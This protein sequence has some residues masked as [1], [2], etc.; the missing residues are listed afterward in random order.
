MSAARTSAARPARHRQPS[1]RR[2][3]AAFRL[4]GERVI[5]KLAG[6]S[7]VAAQFID[8]F[9]SANHDHDYFWEERWI[10]DE[11]YAKLFPRAVKA[12]LGEAGIGIGD[13]ST[14]VL[15]SPLKNSAAGIAKRLGYEG[16]IA[17][18]LEA[19]VGYTGTAHPLLM[20]AGVL[21]RAKAGDRILVL[22]FGQ[23]A[24]ALVLEVTD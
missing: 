17:D 7:T 11:G 2:L 3:A 21:E 8:H 18:G 6:A 16:S 24:E 22:A 9:R 12:A 14:L 4:G 23:G 5:A 20:L 1:C 10:R 15:A 13:I 19:G